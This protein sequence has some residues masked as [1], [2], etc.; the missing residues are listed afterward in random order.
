[1]PWSSRRGQ[2][3]A[4]FR[5]DGAL[6][7][8][9]AMLTAASAFSARGDHALFQLGACSWKAKGKSTAAPAKRKT[10]PSRSQSTNDVLYTRSVA[11]P[12]TAA[13]SQRAGA[14]GRAQAQTPNQTNETASARTANTSAVPGAGRR[15]ACG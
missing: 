14:R 13:A 3:S 12:S 6:R 15:I 5:T 10:A 9:Q 8:V 4:S 2:P 7:N 1:M 11:A